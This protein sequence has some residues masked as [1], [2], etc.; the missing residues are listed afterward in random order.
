M[1]GAMALAMLAIYDITC[2]GSPLHHMGLFAAGLL[3]PHFAHWLFGRFDPRRKHG[4][5]AFVLDGLFVG[6]I[7]GAV[8]FVLVPSA[9]LLAINLFNWIVIGGLRLVLMGAAATALAAAAGGMPTSALASACAPPAW[10]ASAILIAYVAIVARLIRH[11]L[12]TLRRQQ[13]TLQQTTDGALADKARA[14]RALLAVLPPSL[15]NE[16]AERRQLSSQRHEE[17]IV[18]LIELVASAPFT[19]LV[20]DSAYA[21]SET[22]LS[23]NRIEIIK[24]FHGQLLA[25]VLPPNFA[26]MASALAELHGHFRQHPASGIDGIRVYADLGGVELHFVR[27]ER[28]DFELLGAAVDGVFSLAQQYL[29]ALGELRI[30]QNAAARLAAAGLPLNVDNHAT[31]YGFPLDSISRAG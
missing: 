22:I 20:L 13:I 12:E 17:A 30:T 18:L 23:R 11:L 8:D 10:L 26:A 6:G 27:P 1:F 28:L 24:S 3:Y 4:H 14:E 19:P 5:W 16:L 15:A 21:L 29:A 31:S 9:V 25:V 2:H 7:I